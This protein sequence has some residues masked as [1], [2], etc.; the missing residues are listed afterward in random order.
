MK[1]FSIKPYV[2]YMIAD[3]F[4]FLKDPWV[5]YFGIIFGGKRVKN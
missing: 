5:N 4:P 1:K 3:E 2:N